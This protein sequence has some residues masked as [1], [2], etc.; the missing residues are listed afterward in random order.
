MVIEGAAFHTRHQEDKHIIAWARLNNLKFRQVQGS[1][2]GI[3]MKVKLFDISGLAVTQPRKL[4]GV[5]KYG[6]DLKAGVA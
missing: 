1:K 3:E 4:S 2:T 5:A 6:F